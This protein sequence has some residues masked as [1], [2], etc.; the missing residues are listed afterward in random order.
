MMRDARTEVLGQCNFYDSEAKRSW[1]KNCLAQY[2][3]ETFFPI[4]FEKE[5]FTII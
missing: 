3:S 5:K 2:R 1:R 4:Y